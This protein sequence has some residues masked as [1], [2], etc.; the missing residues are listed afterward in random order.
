MIRWLRLL[1]YT[2]DS[3]EQAEK[4][5]QCLGVPIN[6]VY[7]TSISGGIVIRSSTIT[8]FAFDDSDKEDAI[9]YRKMMEAANSSSLARDGFEM[10]EAAM[11]GDD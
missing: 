9:A 5:A 1:E 4:H 11:R 7:K 10:I 6:G 2:F 8:D 3:P